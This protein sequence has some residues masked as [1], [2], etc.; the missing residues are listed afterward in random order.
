M[1]EILNRYLNTKRVSIWGMGYLGYTM[2]LRLQSKGFYAD[3]YDTNPER[4]NLLDSGKYPI[5][6]QKIVWSSKGEV[7]DIDISKICIVNSCEQ[8]LTNSIHIIST[9]SFSESGDANRLSEIA[10]CF[11]INKEKVSDHVVIFQSSGTPGNIDKLFIH[12]LRSNKVKCFYATAFRTDWTLE[13]FFYS[14]NQQVVSGECPKSILMVKSFLNIIDVD[15]VELS[16]IMEA[17]IYECARKSLHYSIEAFVNQIM[18]SYPETNIR[19]LTNLLNKIQIEVTNP[20]IGAIGYKYASAVTYLLEGS[21]FPE[22]FTIIREADSANI[23]SILFYADII[24]HF[25]TD[26]VVIL[27]VCESE[28]QKN[29][30]FSPSLLIAERLLKNGNKVFIHDPFFTESEI[31]DL[32]PGA[33][34]I[35]EL[36]PFTKESCI[37]AMTGH[38]VYRYLTQEDLERLNIFS[39]KLVI[40]NPGLWDKYRFS[41]KTLYHIPGDGKFGLLG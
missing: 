19:K 32:L 20:S 10:E 28:N 37:L 38:R 36:S 34:Y 29:I 41:D 7:P 31:N 14:T 26:Y 33:T 9:P 18:L 39:A 8:L 1:Q 6:E 35:E 22:R 25:I 5:K 12:P 17:E 30:S 40:D 2:L 24:P 15:H 21:T 13:E 11:I 16:S 4:L 27:G 3:V 23:S